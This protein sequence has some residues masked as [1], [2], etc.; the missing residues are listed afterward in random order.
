MSSSPLGVPVIVLIA[1]TSF[2]VLPRAF[3]Q[4]LDSS[5]VADLLLRDEIPQ[6]EALLDRQP[7]TA[8]SAAL[9]GD[10][11]YRKGN[12]EKA[13]SLYREA[14]RMDS[15]TARAHFGLGK[16]ALARL[17]TRQ[18]IQDITRAIQLDPR[19]P[20]YRLHASEAWGIEK[21]Y[22]EQRKQ[23]EEYIRL[24][25]G[26]PG[27]LAEA[28]AGIEVL[29]A[30]GSRAATVH[31]VDNP[32][33][34]PFSKSLN[35]IFTHVMINGRGP[36]DFAI[37]TGASQTVLSEKL[38][39][40]LGL[41]PITSTIMHG[42]GGGGKIETKL[43]TVKEIAVG[44]VKIGNIPVGTFN[45]PLV[46]QLADGILSTSILSD[47][48][49]TVNYPANRLEISKKR[50]LSAAGE[51][52][53]AWYFSN[54]LLVPVELNGRH[55]GN[56]IVDTG[57]VTTVLSHNMAALLGINEKTPDAKVD[58]GIAGVGGFE[59][60][61]LRVPGVTFKTA[62]NREV[63]PQVVAID[64]KEISRMIGTEVSG[65]LGFDFFEDYKL[66]LDYHAAEVRLTK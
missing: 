15:K 32:A 10:I 42:V 30:L 14:L 37:D 59:G 34:I 46:T 48:I 22:T 16:L 61:V 40:E 51:I 4:G 8:G 49:V 5:S 45:D 21:N 2:W 1:L 56:F 19:E 11:E 52:L 29:K 25:P 18:A 47:F 58:L 64:F 66:T 26:D 43:Y 55:R 62:K 33:P 41:T 6:A 3:P 54:L 27:R 39:A 17:K 36:Y 44:D 12:F 57:A 31:V 60:L 50:T 9:R 35:L 38:A 53:P 24:N 28:E 7:R 23:L 13:D 63:F 65:V 20:L